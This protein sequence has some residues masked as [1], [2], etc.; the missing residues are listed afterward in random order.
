MS[1]QF[2]G[3]GAGILADRPDADTVGVALRRA[4]RV[5]GR[6]APRYDADAG[7]AREVGGRLLSRLECAR[8]EP[9]VVL[10][11]GAGTGADLPALRGRYPQAVLLALD[12]SEEM[13]LRAPRFWRR[14]PMRAAGGAHALPLPDASVDL[15]YSNLLLPWCTRPDVVLVELRRV[16]RPGGLL[17][18][19]TLS[20][21]SL[22][23]G[24]SRR[25]CV[26]LPDMQWWGA[27]LLGEGF[28]DPVI[29]VD[30]IRVG[31]SSNL[32]LVR[33]ATVF[34]LGFLLREMRIAAPV[35]LSLELLFGHAC[36]GFSSTRA[37]D[38][39]APIRFWPRGNQLHAALR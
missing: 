26:H 11:L 18:F 31:Y 23:G 29:D 10:D 9:S 34:G 16:L 28:A 39:A 19:S 30:R 32:S 21:A 1:S 20:P 35:E 27:A 36:K 24:G 2:R 17:F 6:V 37:V 5:A 12:A 4:R 25:R 33:D 8:L 15:V 3:G 7:L 13:L 14:R 38:D 22:G